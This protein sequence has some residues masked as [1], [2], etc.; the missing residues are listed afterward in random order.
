MAEERDGSVSS[1]VLYNIADYDDIWPD[2]GGGCTKDVPE[3][4]VPNQVSSP[5]RAAAVHV[6][7]EARAQSEEKYHFISSKE[8]RVKTRK[9][10]S[11]S[12]R[13]RRSGSSPSSV[14]DEDYELSV[15]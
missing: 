1:T 5:T 3:R 2:T 6:E 4:N 8:E 10:K 9:K 11:R 13:R 12:G 7:S 14:S 15:K